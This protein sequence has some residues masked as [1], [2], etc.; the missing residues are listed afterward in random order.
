MKRGKDEKAGKRTQLDIEREQT[1]KGNEQM[2][3]DEGRRSEESTA[4][5]S[6][7]SQKKTEVHA[8]G[9][10]PWRTKSAQRQTPS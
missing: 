10:L 5:A 6:K 4:I 1:E 2:N 7:A 8:M 9:K 3:M